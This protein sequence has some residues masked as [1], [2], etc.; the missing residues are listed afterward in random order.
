M[1]KSYLWLL[2]AFS[3]VL[4][5]PC[6]G[7]AEEYTLRDLY[8]QA[9]INSEKIK[10]AEENLYIA[11]MTKN[12]AWAVLIPR[13]TAYGTYN[14][15]SQEKYKTTVTPLPDP[16]PAMTGSVLIQ[17]SASGNWGVRADQ[18]FSLS[19]REL[20]ALKIAGQGITKS[21][22]DLDYAKMDFIL[23]V[24]SSYYDVLRAQKALDIAQANLDRLAQYRHF[25]DKK[26]KVGEL[27]RTALLRAD[28][29]LSGARADYLR[30][31]NAL[32]LARAALTRVTG[33]DEPFELKE[34]DAPPV[35]AD[36]LDKMRAAAPD[37]R[38]D[39][40]SYEMHTQMASRQV[41][42]A[43]GAFWPQVGLFAV[44]SGLDQ[45]PETAT[46]NK[47]SVF[48]GVSLT[49]PFFEGG[50]RIAEYKEAQ[51]KERQ[52]RLAYEDLK[53]TVDIELR[54]DYLELE[55]Q[56]GTLTFLEDQLVYAR[57]N[58]NAVLR[59]YENG[60][61]TSLD[62]MDANTLLVS[63]E[64]NAADALY[65]FRLAHLK[66][67]KSSGTLLQFIGEEK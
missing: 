54:A 66:V 59:Q 31:Q 42:Y 58:Y 2:I 23:A 20:V 14:H 5:T 3:V 4:L 1:K 43:R 37:A 53:K 57:D 15:F 39:L 7:Q 26:V 24:A 6:R 41:K 17:P 8:Q 12:K 67:R 29:E 46:L 35:P 47:E 65:G 52:A 48:A 56:K 25:V 33:V 38:A 11:R 21:E 22:Y 34:E 64:R 61:A 60:L 49:F 62:V 45:S 55:T 28:G 36:E 51:A 32:K 10:Y 27:T 50:L 30:A 40:K 18:S 16:L 9:L 44:Y 19:A 63:S 13:L